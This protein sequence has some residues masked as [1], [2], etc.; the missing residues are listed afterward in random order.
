[1]IF[2]QTVKTMNMLKYLKNRNSAAQLVNKMASL[3]DD[4]MQFGAGF[5]LGQCWMDWHDF[6]KTAALKNQNYTSV[7]LTILGLDKCSIRVKL[8]LH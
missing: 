5:G 8:N 1:M 7:T 4:S 2:G 3:C 6:V